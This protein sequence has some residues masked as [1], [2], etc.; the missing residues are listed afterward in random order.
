MSEREIFQEALDHTDPAEREA[1]LDRACAGDAALR[2]R[3]EALLGSHASES[4]FLKVP[5]L[6]QI[7]PPSP[8][9]D[10][11]ITVHGNRG[12]NTADE[13]VPDDATD[14]L[15]FLKPSSRPDS[16]GRLG[17]YEVLTVLGK[18]GFGIVF[19]AFDEVL[20]RV[21]AVKV[22]APQMASHSPARKRFLREAQSSARVRHDNVVQVY[23]VEEE[24]LPYLVME[25]VHGETLQQRLSRMGPLNALEVVQIGREIADGLAAAHATG[26]IH[27]DIKPA[28]ILITSG[29]HEHVKITDFGLARAADDAS[30]TQSGVVAGTP[31]YMAPEQASADALDHRTDLFSLGSVLYTICSGRPPFRASSTLAVLK[32]VVDD[33]P[34]PI[35][36]IIPETPQW[37]CDIISKLHQKN[38]DDRYQSAREVSDALANAGAQPQAITKVKDVSGISATKARPSARRKWVAAAAV[39]LLPVIALAVTES[40]G[41]THLFRGQHTTLDANKPDRGL[42]F[43]PIDENSATADADLFDR[44]TF[45]KIQDLLAGKGAESIDASPG[46]NNQMSAGTVLA[47][48]TKEGRYGKCQ[49]TKFDADLELRWLTYDS[50]GEVFS[51]GEGLLVRRSYAYDLDAGKE[52]L[53]AADFRFSST[54]S[55]FRAVVPQDGAVLQPISSRA[56]EPISLPPTFTNNIGMEFVI[57][58]KGKSWL[59]SSKDRL[60]D[61]GVEIPADFYLGKY[62]VTQEQ[63]KKVMGSNPSHFSR[64]GG[65]M[66]AVQD[67][68]DADLNRFPVDNVSWEDCQAFIG[69]LNEMAKESGWMYRLPTG[70]EWEYA[71]RGSPVSNRD[72]HFDFYFA[73][74]TNNLAQ[75]QANFNNVFKRTCK[76]G[77]YEGNSLSLHD[78]H[79]NV[80]EWCEDASRNSYRGLRGG[81][82]DS[83]PGSCRAENRNA[84]PME[85]KLSHFGLR[86]A[87]VPAEVP[88][89]DGKKPPFA[90]APF[91]APRARAHQEA[92][93]KHVGTPVEFKNSVGM[94]M[95]LIPPAIDSAPFY[96]ASCEVTVGQFRRFVEEMNYKTT[97][98]VSKLGGSSPAHYSD[99]QG[100]PPVRNGERKPEFIWNHADFARGDDY[101]VTMISWQDAAAFCAWLSEKEKRTY[102]LPT[103]DE[104]RWAE[105]AGSIARYYFGNV[106]AELGNHA[107]HSGNSDLRS[108]P[109]GLKKPNPWGLFDMYGNVWEL[110][111]DYLRNAERIYTATMK[112]GPKDSDRVTFLG[113]SYCD[114][115]FEIHNRATGHPGVPFGHFG[116]R[117]AIVGDLKAKANDPDR[118]AAEYV[119][120][121]GGSVSINDEGGERDVAT[122]PREAFRLTRIDFRGGNNQV[123][124]AGLAVFKD[125]T[126]LTIL[127]LEGTP[128]GDA[129]LAHFKKCMDLKLA[130]LGFTKLT[131][132]G[133]APFKDWKNLAVLNL[134]ETAVGDVGIANLKEC[135][136]LKELWLQRTQVGDSGLVH[137]RNLKELRQLHL[138]K[139]DVTGTGIEQLKKNVPQ[140][141]IFWDGGVIEAMGLTPQ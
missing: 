119:L 83:V 42:A 45:Q 54:S 28:N 22:L 105:R 115:S 82:W 21:V 100:Q 58:P 32:R 116:F 95:R 69:R 107:W 62:E 7:H 36:E 77:S 31:M 101:P 57:V 5:A 18:G 20:Q 93:A 75:E 131:D 26:L 6:Q 114:P 50:A 76:V 123:S 12:D 17:Q 109:V 108:H 13:T 121:I 41:V 84:A 122:L 103:S 106:A 64:T 44:F 96:L 124:D 104:W 126:N 138:E 49:V 120:S 24:P 79:G 51:K 40:V 141:R 91:G 68:S 66:D 71:C 29:P 86:V 38:P 136:N 25:F 15:A 73:L 23:Q 94:T 128:V 118:K 59:G 102:R 35:R 111:C 4:L 117:V 81:N 16:L 129:G 137:L 63:W 14:D 133:M 1:Y 139:T 80:W 132:A 3:I 74:P 98:E 87:R 47:Y 134:G 9:A 130:W 78:M 46:H 90:I 110:T 55:E 65:G 43:R 10:A 34:R 11:T 61:R 53:A 56:I 48:R 39:L 19:R 135:T 60:V 33:T 2:T 89:T 140:A 88:T 113:G 30:L 8:Q 72:C 97:A 67:A 125:C 52:S 112:T 127:N 92:W 99:L 37:L 85:L 70:D 27:R